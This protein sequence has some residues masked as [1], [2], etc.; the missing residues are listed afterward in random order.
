M[1]RFRYIARLLFASALGVVLFAS[2]GLAQERKGAGEQ[3]GKK[4]H[5]QK[6]D[7]KKSQVKNEKRMEFRGF[8]DENG[9][10][11]DDRMEQGKM[12]HKGEHKEAHQ[13][14]R[15]HF[16][17]MDGDGINDNRCEGM[18]VG[19]KRRSGSWRHMR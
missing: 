16:I 9:D 8:I 12:E 19:N 14:M 11:I 18:G 1:K 10:G 3:S 2:S 13:R 5:Q 7:M 15:D 4:V 6:V 17:D